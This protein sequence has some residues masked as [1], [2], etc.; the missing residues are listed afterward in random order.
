MP[1]EIQEKA[2]PIHRRMEKPPIICLRNL[3]ISGV[4]LGGVSALGPSRARI[5]AA[6]ALERPCRRR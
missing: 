5:S 3:T 1:K 2:A 4:A 6:L